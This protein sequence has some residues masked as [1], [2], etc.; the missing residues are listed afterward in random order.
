MNDR[1]ADRHKSQR[2]YKSGFNKVKEKKEKQKKV[3]EL[4]F[5]TRRMTDFLCTDQAS[6]GISTNLSTA[7]A[8]RNENFEI[9]VCEKFLVEI[10]K[11]TNFEI[12]IMFSFTL[13]VMYNN[14]INFA[15]I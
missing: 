2:V 1:S 9:Q 15:L 12:L 5:Q 3:E 11:P 13:Y 7:T 6:T 14:S 8:I 4:L 10:I